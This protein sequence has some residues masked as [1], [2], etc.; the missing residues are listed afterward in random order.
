MK[1][2]HRTGPGNRG[3]PMENRGE[4]WRQRDGLRGKE[5]ERQQAGKEAWAGR[6]TAG[7]GGGAEKD[8][9]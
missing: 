6:Q 2:G 1:T 7:M 5:M 9:R 8:T 3:E 4:R